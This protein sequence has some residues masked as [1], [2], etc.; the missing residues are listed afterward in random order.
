MDIKK[1]LY[2]FLLL[3]IGCEPAEQTKFPFQDTSLSL[4]ERVDDLISRMTL[5]EKVSQMRYD[6]P[7]I[8]RLGIPEY[9]WW[10]ECLHGVGRAG[11]ATVFPQAIGMA[12][13]WNEQLM[14]DIAEAISDEA[15]A[16]HHRFADEGKRG[17]YMGLTFWTPNINIF[18]DPRWGRGQETYGEDPY[19]TGRLAV[20]FINGLQGDHEK[21][22]KTVATS[23]HFA[24]H[25]G[26]EPLR[27]EFNAEVSDKDLYET[28]LPHFRMTIEEAN[29][30]SVMCAYNALHGEPCCGSDPLLTN[31]LRN[32]FGFDGYIVSDCW[33]IEDFF[34]PDDHGVVETGQEAAALAV[35]S[36]TDLNCGDTYHPY[37]KQAVEQGLIDEEQLDI[38]LKRLFTARFKL[39]MFD[40][41]ADVPFTSIAY[42]VVASDEHHRLALQA[43]RE[44]IVLLKNENNLLPLNQDINSIA[45]IGPNADN[46]EVMLGNYH[47]TPTNLSTVLDGIREKAGDEIEVNYA[48]GSFIV[49]GLP[50]LHPIPA[51]ALRASGDDPGLQAAYYDNVDW[52]GEPAIQRTDSVID[53]YWLGNSPVTEVPADT[54]SVRWKGRLIAPKTGSYQIGVNASQG[55]TLWIDGEEQL[56]M[57]HDHRPVTHTF[58][59]D[60][61]AGQSYEVQLDFYNAG[62]DPQAH[63]LWAVPDRDLEA[64]A[65]EAARRSDVAV[66]VMGIHPRIEGEEMGVELQ[67]FKGG[68][69]TD[70]QLPAV[71]TRLIKKIHALGK[72]VILVLMGGG[73]ISFPWE[74]ENVPAIIHAWYPGEFGG[75]A[76]ADI[77]FGDYN[78]SGKLPVT[79]YSSVNDLPPFTSYDMENR[80]YKY[81]SGEPLYPFGH[82]LSYTSFNYANLEMPDRIEP[83]DSL[84][85]SV[86][87]TNSGQMA[88][89]E[90]VQLYLTDVDAS[91]V[92]PV[93]ALCGF[94]RTTL[95]PGET[96]TIQFSLSPKQYAVVNDN[97]KLTI[98]PGEFFVSVGGKQPGFEGNADAKTTGTTTG[99]FMVEGETLILE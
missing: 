74:N 32:E 77:L 8:E 57:H 88:G 56:T 40:D 97:G 55:A 50:S 24:V 52:E 91:F 53:F 98:E 75:N 1:F 96:K 26:P 93:R 60:L 61:E 72:P 87:I 84:N 78:P 73:A 69:R 18:R 89:T 7:A 4:E 17:I 45:V 92:T 59:I 29:V 35:K 46:Y 47:G 43:S 85:I 67:G 3:C 34:N 21:Y 37:L 20:N 58:D 33:A 82:G 76:I 79:F 19:L 63:L 99:S 66:M 68:D 54:F 38:S 11:V 25:S 94:Q 65:I 83:G 90:T 6:A 23:K 16:K 14:Y 27:H 31:I 64:D 28:Y 41:P 81:F 95:E 36:G 15:R 44:S 30:E 51:S 62:T 49:E 12:S 39:G 71:Q 80:T 10:N 5:E 13:S 86:E 22:L 2:L 42:D 9:N 48:E 70:I